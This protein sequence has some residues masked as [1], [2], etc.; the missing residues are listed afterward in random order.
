MIAKKIQHCESDLLHI[1]AQLFT[2]IN[3]K[4]KSISLSKSRKFVLLFLE[5]FC[6]KCFHLC[7]KQPTVGTNLLATSDMTSQHTSQCTIEK[8]LLSSHQ[9]GECRVGASEQEMF[10][11]T[12]NCRTF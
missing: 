9:C 2:T 10:L 7:Y 5:C 11:M 12:L 1:C 8:T 6:I 3:K 4:K